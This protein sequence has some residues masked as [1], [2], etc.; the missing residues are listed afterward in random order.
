MLRCLSSIA[1]AMLLFLPAVPAQAESNLLFIFDASGSMK[2]TIDSGETRLAVAKRAMQDALGRMPTDVR[3]GLLL[4]GHRRG[5]DCTDIELVSPIGADPAAAL[6]SRIAALD[7]K[8]ETPIAESLRQAMRSFAPLEAQSNRVVLVTDGIEECGGDPCAAAAE[9]AAAGVN[10]KVDVIG[11][12]LDEQQR[13]TV[14]CI[15]EATGGTYYDAQDRQTLASAFTQVE[16]VVM[17]E[18]EPAIP[19]VVFFDEFDGTD[20]G[21]DWEVINP[22][23]NNFIV[24]NGGLLIVNSKQSQLSDG[25]V[26]NLFK[27]KAPLPEGDWILSA[28]M[29][30]DFQTGEEEVVIGAYDNP[31]TF[32]L[33]GTSFT[34]AIIPRLTLGV[35][36]SKWMG[37]DF[38]SF[39]QDAW[40]TLYNPNTDNYSE[41]AKQVPQPVVLQL[42]KEGRSYFGA[43]ILERENDKRIELEKLTSLRTPGHFVIAVKQN[44]AVNGET[45]AT[46][47]W[48]RIE[49]VN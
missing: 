13:R 42:R 19:N 24:E 2:K 4:Y 12:T 8:G 26:E 41:L 48:V 29:T 49:S 5:K 3:L 20:L 36:S 11:F 35:F 17:A 22:N 28:R 9:V 21:L 39:T 1:V 7:G 43:I 16:Q 40:W 18:P 44:A 34:D 32:I 10:L 30:I 14:Q 6:A 37:G 33:T 31:D 23:R 27:L 25:T 15:T 46:I 47:D 45:V 38:S